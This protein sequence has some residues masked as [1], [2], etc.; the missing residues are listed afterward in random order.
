[1]SAS[2]MVFEALPF[3]TL[4]PFATEGRGGEDFQCLPHVDT[5]RPVIVVLITI[6]L[7]EQ[8]NWNAASIEMAGGSAQQDK[9]SP[10]LRGREKSWRLSRGLHS[11]CH[12]TARHAI[13]SRRVACL[14]SRFNKSHSIRLWSDAHQRPRPGLRSLLPRR[15]RHCGRRCRLAGKE[16]ALLERPGQIFPR[17]RCGAST[18]CPRL[19]RVC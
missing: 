13:E 7:F 8:K 11:A 6:G 14:V 12:C 3:E 2:N 15:E 4:A 5:S 16:E 19:G 10:G 18:G 9:R 1:L 17:S